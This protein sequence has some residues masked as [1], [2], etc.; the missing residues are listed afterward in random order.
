[1]NAATTRPELVTDL[2]QLKQDSGSA[3]PVGLHLAPP[4]PGLMV[5]A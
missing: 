4:L 2:E 3:L 1:M 5:R